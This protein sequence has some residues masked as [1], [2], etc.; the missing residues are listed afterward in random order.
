MKHKEERLRQ[1][2]ARMQ[3]RISDRL[4]EV[5]VSYLLR[6]LFALAL[7]IGA[8]FWPKATIALLIQLVGIFAV[9]NGVA[10]LLSAWQARLPGSYWLP[11]WF[12]L[13][14]GA[15]LLFWPGVTVRLLF[16]IVGIWAAIQ[17]GS[18]WMMARETAAGDPDRGLLTGIG[19]T[20]VVIGL[21]LV[22]WPGTGAVAI[23][24]VIAAVA[25]TVGSLLVY[26]GLHLRRG[27]R[28][29]G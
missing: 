28:Y 3:G 2:A 4:G 25:L 6:G 15:V 7:G 13:A 11:G 22:F 9:L 10:S 19:V 20:G 29:H 23:S 21:V 5:W 1:V 8:L 27:G 26:L 24:W 12:S 18:L 17:G 16:I 14:A